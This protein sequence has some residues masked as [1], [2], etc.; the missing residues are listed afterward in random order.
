MSLKYGQ[1]TQLLLLSGKP[2]YILSMELNVWLIFFSRLIKYNDCKWFY[3]TMHFSFKGQS[4]VIVWF[5][6][7][8]LD[9]IRLLHS[10]EQ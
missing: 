3:I 10:S 9:F 7:L 4:A 8:L 2:E 1:C 6:Q 5:Q